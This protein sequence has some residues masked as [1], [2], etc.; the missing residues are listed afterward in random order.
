MKKNEIVNSVLEL[1]QDKSGPMQQAVTRWVGLVM[2]DIASR[3]HLASLERED[4]ASMVSGQR[5]YQLPESTEKVY[6]VFVPTWGSPE[7]RLVKL[8]QEKFLGEMLI[9]GFT[10]TGR[11]KWYSIFA[12]N[13]LRLHPIPNSDNAPSGPTDIQKLHIYRRVQFTALALDDDIT[14]IKQS[15]IPVIIWGAYSMGAVFDSLI[16]ADRALGR[17]EAGIKRIYAQEAT[18]YERANTVAYNGL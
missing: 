10:F 4:T 17:Y 8:N 15:H 7:G 11:P 14:E 13:T 6:A 12:D 5:D 1:V 3:G 9:D 2:D 16:D 18:D